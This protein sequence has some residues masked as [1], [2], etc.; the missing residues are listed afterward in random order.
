MECCSSLFEF[1]VW[2]WLLNFAE[3]RLNQNMAMKASSKKTKT[4]IT[5]SS[6]SS[7][8][9]SSMYV[10]GHGDRMHVRESTQVSWICLRSGPLWV[11]PTGP[12]NGRDLNRKHHIVKSLPTMQS[13]TRRLRVCRS[14]SIALQRWL[15]KFAKLLSFFVFCCIFNP[16]FA[17]S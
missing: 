3:P 8:M 6:L 7:L 4:F 12:R 15:A 14:A 16:I 5:T 13:R 17:K 11:I 2:P 1:T 9:A 10:H